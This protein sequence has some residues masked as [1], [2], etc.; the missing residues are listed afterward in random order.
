MLKQNIVVIGGGTGNF[1]TLSGLKRHNCYLTAIVSMAD[2]GGST[3]RLRDEYGVLPPGDIRQCLIALSTSDK[4]MRDLFSYRFGN[5]SLNGHNFGNLLLAAL[6]KTIGNFEDAVKRVS[7]VLAIKGQVIPV[8]TTMATLCAILEDGTIIKKETKIDE[9]DHDG[10]LRIK[11]IFLEPEANA[12]TNAIKAI[13]EAD[14]IVIPPGDVYT[15]ILPN[16]IVKGISEAIK[17]SKAKKIFVCNL[18][19]K[20]GQTN[21]FTAKDHLGI[22]RK[23]IDIDYA[24]VNTTKPSKNI[25]KIYEK[26]NEFPV[27]DDLKLTDKKIIRGDFLNKIAIKKNR[28]DALRRSLIRHNPAKLAMAIINL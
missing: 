14:K 18:M 21:N 3:G 22:I 11:D 25:L 6:T 19:T 5:G 23:Y 20:Y 28:A 17:R 2:D 24:I 12:N 13:E 7:E 26:E 27:V 4:V 9:P 15:S 8:T 10:T 16:L 1:V